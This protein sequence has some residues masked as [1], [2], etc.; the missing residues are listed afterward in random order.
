MA[1]PP[2]T[3]N[4]FIE[5]A[6]ELPE[7]ESDLLRLADLLVDLKILEDDISLLPFKYITNFSAGATSP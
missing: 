5:E 1:I 3:P 6:A 4:D 2:A 7:V